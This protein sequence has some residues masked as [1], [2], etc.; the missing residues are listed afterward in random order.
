MNTNTSLLIYDNVM[1]QSDA[2]NLR[3]TSENGMYAVYCFLL[4]MLHEIALIKHVYFKICFELELFMRFYFITTQS[5]W[6][7]RDS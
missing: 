4:K 6:W 5:S 2:C 7:H 3:I 1:M